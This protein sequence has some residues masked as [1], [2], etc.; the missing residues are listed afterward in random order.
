VTFQTTSDTVSPLP[1]AY[2]ISG[3]QIHPVRLAELLAW[4]EH[5]IHAQQRVFVTYANIH[6]INL[7]QQHTAFREV[8]NSADVVFCDGQGLRVGAAL[9]GYSIPERFTPP[10]WIDALAASCTAHGAR[11]FLLGG[12]PGVAEAAV[13]RLSDRHPGLHLAAH[14]GYLRDSPDDEKSALDAISAFQPSLLLVGMGMPLQEC[15]IAAHREQI[16]APV[17][18]TVGALFDYLAGE[19]V[20]GP[21]WLTD[22]GFEWLCRLWYEPRRLW[23]RYLFGNPMFLFLIARQ[24]VAERRVGCKGR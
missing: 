6:A 1:A 15:W 24:W 14:H 20:R 10:D 19:V 23:R 16:A 13:R 3:V 7:A 18:M 2:I 5:A 11:V 12:R 22:N 4:I 17:V 8:L 9:L 21:H